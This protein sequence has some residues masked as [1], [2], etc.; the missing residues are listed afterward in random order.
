MDRMLYSLLIEKRA[1]R[2]YKRIKQRKEFNRKDEKE[3][4]LQQDPEKAGKLLYCDN[5]HWVLCTTI[6]RNETRVQS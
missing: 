3:K 6:S 1:R 4:I 5:V 2:Q